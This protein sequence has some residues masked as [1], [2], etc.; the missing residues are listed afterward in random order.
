MTEDGSDDGFSYSIPYLGVPFD[1]YDVGP[2]AKNVSSDL[3]HDVP[4]VL[5]F[6]SSNYLISLA[7]PTQPNLDSYH[8]PKTPNDTQKV[9]LLRID[10]PLPSLFS[11]VDLVPANISFQPDH[12]GFDPSVQIKYQRSDTPVYEGFLGVPTHGIIYEA[13][14]GPLPVD[15]PAPAKQLFA[16]PQFVSSVLSTTVWDEHMREVNFTSGDYRPLL[17]SLRWGGNATDAD[18]YE[19]WLGPVIRATV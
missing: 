16:F 4:A 18:D 6:N 7:E 1:Q 17:R 13:G 14:V 10:I 15:D 2:V 3:V 19:S 11:R 8:W 5:S 12:Y 9:P